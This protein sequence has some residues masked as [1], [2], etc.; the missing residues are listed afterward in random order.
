[1]QATGSQKGVRMSRELDALLAR[2]DDPA[3]RAD[4]ERQID[5]VRAKRSFGLVFESHLPERVRLPSHSVRRGSN[6]V[7]R[8]DSDDRSWTVELV[9]SKSATIARPDED[10][11]VVPLAGLVVVAEFG[12]PI[13]PGFRS[14]AS[15]CRGGTKPA[16]VVV[17]GENHHALEALQFTHTGRVDCIYIDPP[18][19]TGARDWKYDNDYVDGEDAYRHSKWL[20]FMERRLLLAKKL[21]KPDDS[22]LIVT[23]DEKEYLRLGMLLEQTFPEAAIQMVSIVINPSGVSSGGGLSRVE[24]YA[25]FCFF[26][27]AQPAPQVRDLLDDRPAGDAKAGKAKVRWEWL[28]RGGGS[29]YRDA[30]PN[31]CYP[32]VLNPEGDRIVDVGMPWSGD[33]ESSRPTEIDG[34]PLAWPVRRDNRLGIWRVE[35]RRLMELVDQGYAFVSEHSSNNDRWT[36]RYLLGGTI[37]AIE[38]GEI[39]V[40]GTGKRGQ[41]LVSGLP[42]A[43]AVPKT[44]WKS[45][46]HIAGGAGGTQLLASLLG[47]RN[48]FTFP[49]SLYAVEDALGTAIGDKPNALVLDFFA[50]SGTTTHAVA[51]LNRR[52]GGRRRSIMITNNEVSEAEAKSLVK[53]GRQPGDREWEALGIFEDVTL[54]RITAAITGLTPG[55]QPIKGDYKVTDEFP[56]SEGFE[57]NIEFF[58]LTYQDGERV[59]LDLAFEAIAPL[60]W[61]RAGST[62]PVVTDTHDSDGRPVAYGFGETYAV[63]FNPDRW[64]SFLDRVTAAVRMVFIVTDSTTTFASVAGELPSN[65]E[66]VRLYRNYLSTFEINRGPGA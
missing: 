17:N 30:R 11:R 38:K 49:K 13:Y 5:L 59:E 65:V 3:L 1:M 56:M 23:I 43:R 10:A 8:D 7:F 12:E 52:D 42:Q 46:S 66:P 61:L 27:V 2:I 55:G 48:R 18:Y 22:V 28:L 63:L 47:K 25:Y 6:V 57:E 64:R 33:D 51:R 24:E 58:E 54:P 45:A 16:H 62:G 31:L 41:V 14:V 4:L 15:V 32:I 34:R 36:I 21:L 19:N 35:G 50:G 20:A 39:E 40:T 37:A 26:G 29:W 9:R 60:L 44:V 53:E